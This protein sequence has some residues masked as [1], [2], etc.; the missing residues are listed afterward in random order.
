MQPR[1]GTR[2]FCPLPALPAAVRLRPGVGLSPVHHAEP[3]ACRHCPFGTQRAAAPA[4]NPGVGLAGFREGAGSSHRRPQ[5]RRSRPGSP[6]PGGRTAPCPA[7][8]RPA[9]SPRGRIPGLTP[10]CSSRPRAAQRTARLAPNAVGQPRHPYRPAAPAEVQD[11]RRG[12]APGKQ[13]RSGK[14]QHPVRGAEPGRR[15][16]L[17]PNSTFV[18]AGEIRLCFQR[19]P[20]RCRSTRYRPASDPP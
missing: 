20:D 12:A 6:T 13:A 10:V 17:T 7:P 15:G 4:P 2:G 3:M 14:A 16:A 8:G 1:P 5:A 11:R 9:A 18:S 19:P